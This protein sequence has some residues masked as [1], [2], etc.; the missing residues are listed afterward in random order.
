MCD[1]YD[2][3]L[4]IVSYSVQKFQELELVAKALEHRIRSESMSHHEQAEC[5]SGMQRIRA[6]QNK[7]RILAVSSVRKIVRE[8]IA[9]NADDPEVQDRVFGISKSVDAYLKRFNHA[10]SFKRYLGE[11][12]RFYKNF[13]KNAERRRNT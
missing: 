5:I 9:K 2:S 12:S 11:N 1:F 6:D 8:Y 13:G 4:S 7:E 3:V 10:N